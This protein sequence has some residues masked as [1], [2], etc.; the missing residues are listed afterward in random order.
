MP[1]EEQ[2]PF[3]PH[4]SLSPFVLTQA[5]VLHSP[6][7][8]HGDAHPAKSPVSAAASN[9]DFAGILIIRSLFR[10]R[11]GSNENLRPTS[12]TRPTRQIKSKAL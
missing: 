3:D 5:L 4:E 6:F 12:A 9:N 8:Q 2:L 7:L 11:A 10:I 1:F